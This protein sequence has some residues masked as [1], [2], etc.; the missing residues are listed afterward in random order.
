MNRNILVPVA[1]LDDPGP[2]FY[3]VFGSK[4]NSMGVGTFWQYGPEVEK[5]PTGCLGLLYL[6]C[7]PPVHV[8]LVLGHSVL[9]TK[10]R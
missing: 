8:S 2:H 3:D 5:L 1:T 10:R 7:D 9:Q 4:N 6:R